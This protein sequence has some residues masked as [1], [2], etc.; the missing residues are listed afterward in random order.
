MK[1]FTS[2]EYTHI[3]FTIDCILFFVCY[4][5]EREPIKLFLCTQG[6]FNI[7]FDILLDLN[8]HVNMTCDTVIK[9]LVYFIH[10]VK[11]WYSNPH[12]SLMNM[13]SLFESFH[14]FPIP[15][16]HKPSYYYENTYGHKFVVPELKYPLLVFVEKTYAAILYLWF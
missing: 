6:K 12:Q 14:T 8:I 10:R 3:C 2:K 1:C 16:P 11:V 13:S 9:N 4:S 7:W 5:S 15:S